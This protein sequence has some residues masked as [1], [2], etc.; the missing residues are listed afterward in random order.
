M[1]LNVVKSMTAVLN[2]DKGKVEKSLSVIKGKLDI[3]V[4]LDFAPFVSKKRVKFGRTNIAEDVIILRDTGAAQSLLCSEVVTIPSESFTGDSVLVHGIEGSFESVPL[5]EI[6]L[7]S[8]VIKG[9][10][11]IGVTKSCPVRGIPLVLGNDLSGERVK[12]QKPLLGKYPQSDFK[13]DMLEND[14]PCI[15]PA[16]VTTLN[17]ISLRPS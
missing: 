14:S 10:V 17:T 13:T 15:F 8:D 1:L 12:V 5:C 16:C 6:E 9:V 3:P 11:S 2:V 4:D 7:Q